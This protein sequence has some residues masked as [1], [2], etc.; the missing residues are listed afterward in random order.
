[1]CAR[2][3]SSSLI[4]GNTAPLRFLIDFGSWSAYY[5]QFSREA[6]KVNVTFNMY[7]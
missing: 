5:A 2:I 4:V 3:I 7:T 6:N 1:M